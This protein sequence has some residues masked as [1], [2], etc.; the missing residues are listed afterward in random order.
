MF[1]LG[2]PYPPEVFGE[3]RLLGFERSSWFANFFPDTLLVLLDCW[4]ALFS[5]LCEQNQEPT[6][7]KSVDATWWDLEKPTKRRHNFWKSISTS[8]F[9]CCS[10]A[11]QQDECLYPNCEEP[12]SQVCSNCGRRQHA[13][14]VEAPLG[15]CVGRG[16]AATTASQH[17]FVCLQ[18]RSTREVVDRQSISFLTTRASYFLR[19]S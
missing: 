3:S 13:F 7:H 9:Y 5:F 2:R 19:Q 4:R 12:P 8:T 18:S 11:P 1:L 6:Y 17:L 15:R 16:G 14:R 10:F